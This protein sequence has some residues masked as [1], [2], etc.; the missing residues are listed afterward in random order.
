MALPNNID[1]STP[2]GTDSPSLGDDQFR[3]LKT[4]LIDVAGFT[5]GTNVTNRAFTYNTNGVLDML[6]RFT[7]QEGAAIASAAALTLGADGNFF[8]I[9][10]TTGIT[11]IAS[12]T[13]A[14][15]FFLVFDDAVTITHN[16][17]SLILIGGANYTTVAGDILVFMHEGSGNYREIHRFM[18]GSDP[19]GTA[20]TQTLTNK[21]LTTPT[22]AATGWTNA[23][24]VHEAANSGGQL[25]ATNVFSAG[26]IPTARLGSGTASSTTFLRGDQTWNAAVTGTGVSTIELVRKTADETVN[27]STTLQNDDH[28]LFSIAANEVVH[29]YIACFYVSTGATPDLKFAFSAPSGAT[30][31]LSR[32]GAPAT[33]TDLSD[34][35]IAVDMNNASITTALIIGTTATQGIAM[36]FFTI[37][38]STTAGTVN[39]QWAQ[40]TA[41]AENTI[42]RT[43]SYLLIFRV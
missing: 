2:A 26:T 25:N 19:V 18:T 17:T 20:K 23:G 24:H 40:N 8:H 27:N 38:N 42:M 22:I 31:Q 9:T 30:G 11:S 14:G 15:P 43:D 41:T 5:S 1:S 35:N 16:A 6:R 36:V 3:D 39:F 29:G 37:R 21:T 10:G 12:V 4:F 33:T 13:G 32:I 34:G 7:L 28:L